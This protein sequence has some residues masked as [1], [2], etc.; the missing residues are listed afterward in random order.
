[1]SDQ[2]ANPEQGA[3][4]E[5][6]LDALFAPEEASEEAPQEALLEESPDS[7]EQEE[8]PEGDEQE[9]EDAD[10]ESADAESEDEEHE[11]QNLLEIAEA[12]GK[13]PEELMAQLKS[14]VKVNGQELEVTLDE[15]HKGY[16]MEAD[17]R[18]KT[19]E[20]AETRKAFEAEQ[21]KTKNDLEQ[22]LQQTA[23]FSEIMDQFILQ[24]YNSI[25]WNTLR[26]ENPGEFA[27]YQAEFQN[28]MQQVNQIKSQLGQQLE[29]MQAEAKKQQM[30]AQLEY[31]NKER[32]LL[33]EAVPEFKDT[34][35]A[36]ELA[37]N[38]RNFL[39]S[40]GF[41]DQE[42]GGLVDHKQVLLVRDAMAY[43]ALKSGKPEVQ[44]KVSNAPKLQKPGS[45]Q[46]K[47]KG[48]VQ[49]NQLRSRLKKSGRLEDA[50]ALID[51]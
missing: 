19:S 15:L 43:Q 31:L 12:L 7:E 27:A 37:T 1:M 33:A 51:L 34:T 18:R 29:Q 8:A 20:L 36:Q 35:K 44:K 45:T 5:D 42:I 41:T 9:V 3:S 13:T 28:R 23:Q 47:S 25:D 46:K 21:E 14:K 30:E 2:P 17:Y 24:D 16:Q 11:F 50:M 48:E 32:E 39:H 22:R 26:A 40:K 6:R 49:K 10:T 38:M 4:V